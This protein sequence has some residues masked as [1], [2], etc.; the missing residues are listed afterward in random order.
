MKKNQ[1]KKLYYIGE[2]FVHLIKAFATIKYL[3]KERKNKTISLQFQE[4]IMLAVTEVNGCAM[5]SYAHTK[6]ALDAGL[7]NDEISQLLEGSNQENTPDDELNAILFSSYYADCRGKVEKSIW[8][9]IVD[10]YNI[11]KALGILGA[12]RMI[13]LGNILGIALGSF[14]SRFKKDK[15][16][17]DS[18]TTLFY[19]LVIILT[20]I[21]L[22]LIAFVISLFLRLFKVK[23]I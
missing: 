9:K 3:T 10:E 13:T 14:I 18:R 23:L 12:I 17:R 1:G 4:R 6:M 5:C 15:S 19:E 11:D 21:P 8:Q 22:S 20:F 2:T 7:S 16:H